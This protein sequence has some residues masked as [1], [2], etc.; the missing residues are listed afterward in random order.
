MP[1]MT[2]GHTEGAQRD[3][4][5]AT[6]YVSVGE[7]AKLLGIHRNTVHHRIKSGRIRA[8]KVLEGDREVYRIERDS[9]GIED[10]G[11]TSADVRTLDAQRPI[12]GE[13]LAQL[14][15]VKLEEIVQGHA[16]EL[17]DVREQLGEERA[18]RQHAEEEAE[19]LRTELE[20]ER[21]KGFWRR[22]FGG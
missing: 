8:H 12:T 18:K 6:Q 20:A 15:S 10:V 16:L 1:R 13:A 3:A 19:R 2:E 4:Q 11:R 5:P 9:L 14:L 7:A 22:L 17:G 21:S